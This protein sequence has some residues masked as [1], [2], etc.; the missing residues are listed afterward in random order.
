MARAKGTCSSDFGRCGGCGIPCRAAA[1]DF[2]SHRSATRR[3]GRRWCWKCRSTW[4]IT[5]CAP[6]P[7]MPPTAC[8]AACLLMP[9]A[10]RSWSRSARRPWGASSTC[11]GRPVDSM[12]ASECQAALPDP[13]P[14]AALFRAIHPRRSL[15]DRHQSHRPDRPLHQRRQDRHLWRRGRGQDRH[16]HGADPLD[17]HRAPGQLGVCRCGRAHPRRHP[18]LP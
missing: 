9:P 18:A 1:R 10:R 7:W 6:W 12:G 14:G 11:L 3:Q 15:R 8:S 5:G 17:R 16:H 13:P 4:A 2:R